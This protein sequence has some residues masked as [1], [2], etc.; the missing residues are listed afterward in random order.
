MIVHI[1]YIKDFGVL[2]NKTGDLTLESR[3]SSVVLSFKFY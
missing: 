3:K 1:L 2:I